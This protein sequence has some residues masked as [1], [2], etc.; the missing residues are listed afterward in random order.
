MERGVNKLN[1]HNLLNDIVFKGHTYTHN[2]RADNQG[3]CPH[4]GEIAPNKFF[5][6]PEDSAF[7][8]FKKIDEKWSIY[9]FECPKCF[10]KF[11]YHKENDMVGFDM[12]NLEYQR[13]KK[14]RIK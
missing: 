2:D 6:K 3:Q 7:I 11:F 12:R 13:K 5:W 14:R 4:C 9:C 1:G 8:G 10:E